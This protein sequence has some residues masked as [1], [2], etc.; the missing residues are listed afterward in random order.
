MLGLWSLLHVLFLAQH[1]T[2]GMSIKAVFRS[3]LSELSIRATKKSVSIRTVSSPVW[4][5]G[6]QLATLATLATLASWTRGGSTDAGGRQ[7]TV[8]VR[9]PCGEGIAPRQS[10]CP[11]PAAA[12]LGRGA[13]GRCGRGGS[14][15]CGRRRERERW[16]SGWREVCGSEGAFKQQVC[17]GATGSK[18]SDWADICS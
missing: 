3:Y 13:G 14:E 7:A 18:W 2:R 11:N 16:E 10:T 6:F 1:Q 4:V 9:R 15:W 8:S 12:H 5:G 17:G